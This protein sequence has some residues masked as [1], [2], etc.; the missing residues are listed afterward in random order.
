M[1]KFSWR[2]SKAVVEAGVQIDEVAFLVQAG[3]FLQ[4]K[5]RTSVQDIILDKPTQV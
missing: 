2:T 3:G 5:Q 1:K 4:I